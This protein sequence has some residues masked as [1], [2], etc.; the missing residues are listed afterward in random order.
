MFAL[1]EFDL[2]T[3]EYHETKDSLKKAFVFALLA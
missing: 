2:D 3:Y 1:D